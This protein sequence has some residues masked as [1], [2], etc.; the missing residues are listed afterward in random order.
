MKDSFIEKAIENF[1]SGLNSGFHKS[2]IYTMLSIAQ[3]LKL[4]REQLEYMSK[5]DKE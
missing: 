1:N 5:K 4:I 2:I 3:E